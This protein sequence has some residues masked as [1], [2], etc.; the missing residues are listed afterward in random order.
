[1][2]T[3]SK[4]CAVRPDIGWRLEASPRLWRMCM[5]AMEV[6]WR[7]GEQRHM[8]GALQIDP[9]AFTAI[10]GGANKLAEDVNYG[11]AWGME[12]ILTFSLVMM[13]SAA[14]DNFHAATT[15]HLPVS[16]CLMNPDS[17]N[18]HHSAL[19]ALRLLK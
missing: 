18:T 3:A 5:S 17:W 2:I 6:L 4:S 11:Q 9:N 1:M 14:T 19:R 8:G 13:V 12:A 16:L 10:G 15:A 7:A